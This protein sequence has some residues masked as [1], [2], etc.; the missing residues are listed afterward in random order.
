MFLMVKLQ[1]FLKLTCFLCCRKLSKEPDYSSISKPS[2]TWCFRAVLLGANISFTPH[3]HNKP[4]VIK[5]NRHQQKSELMGSLCGYPSLQSRLAATCVIVQPC[6][7]RLSPVRGKQGLGLQE[8]ATY[9]RSGFGGKPPK[10]SCRFVLLPEFNCSEDGGQAFLFP[11]LENVKL[12][13][14]KMLITT[15]DL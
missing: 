10:F 6:R 14:S 13:K 15:V 12:W 1:V 8:K 3:W 5:W 9:F 7:H 11:M 2:P 4:V